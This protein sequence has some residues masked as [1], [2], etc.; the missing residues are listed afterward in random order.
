MPITAPTRPS[1]RRFSRRAGESY[2]EARDRLYQRECEDRDARLQEMRA[3]YEQSAK[4]REARHQREREERER[5]EANK[6]VFDSVALAATFIAG[7]YLRDS[8]SDGHLVGNTLSEGEHPDWVL[9]FHNNIMQSNV[10]GNCRLLDYISAHGDDGLENVKSK[11]KRIARSESVEKLFGFYVA[12]STVIDRYLST[13]S[14]ADRTIVYHDDIKQ[15]IINA[16]GYCVGELV[17]KIWKL[18]ERS[19]KIIAVEPDIDGGEWGV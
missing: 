9:K 3:Q 1:H 14:I 15:L 18:I 17:E 5:E 4:E 2:Q 19:T 16:K 7:R 11:I 6:P 12:N 8:Y 10:C 13:A